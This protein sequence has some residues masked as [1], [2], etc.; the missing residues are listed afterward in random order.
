MAMAMGWGGVE[1]KLRKARVPINSIRVVRSRRRR[2]LFSMLI[3]RFS[4][5]HPFCPI[6]GGASLR[7]VTSRHVTLTDG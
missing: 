4:V 5:R 1:R 7:L 6:C 2:R 3:S